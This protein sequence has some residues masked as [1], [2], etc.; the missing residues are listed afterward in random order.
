MSDS[1][2]CV[3]VL[4]DAASRP[5]YVGAT[6]SVARRVGEHRNKSWW[7]YVRDVEVYPQNSWDL[8]LYVE[9]NLI[10]KL[11]PEFNRQSVDEGRQMLNT[12]FGQSF[13]GI[14]EAMGL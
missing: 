10:R 8:A 4:V 12:F 3:Y 14:A 1:Q 2:P 5:L 7:K 6:R 11:S 13:R 9:R